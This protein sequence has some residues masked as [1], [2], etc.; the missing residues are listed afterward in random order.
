MFS[1]ITCQ[2]DRSPYQMQP[3][4]FVYNPLEN[5]VH[6]KKLKSNFIH[7]YILFYFWKIRKTINLNNYNN[8]CLKQ[9]TRYNK[10][11]KIRYKR[12]NTRT[13]LP[14]AID[15]VTLISHL[16]WTPVRLNLFWLQK[17]FKTLSKISKIRHNIFKFTKLLQFQA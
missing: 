14:L 2:P 3:N 11:K 13:F 15:A 16:K 1:Q 12:T 9:S 5:S 17:K 8:H 6:I 7:T 4:N 10:N